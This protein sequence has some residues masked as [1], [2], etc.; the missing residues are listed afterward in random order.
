[1]T[2]KPEPRWRKPR[3]TP[4]APLFDQQ[5]IPLFDPKPPEPKPQPPPPEPRPWSQFP[6]PDEDAPF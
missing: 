3:R 1:V 6:E 4:P 5:Q 2:W